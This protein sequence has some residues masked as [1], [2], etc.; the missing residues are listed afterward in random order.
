MRSFSAGTAARGRAFGDWEEWSVLGGDALAG[1][2]DGPAP[3]VRG[4]PLAPEEE[5]HHRDDVEHPDDGLDHGRL[6]CEVDG[7]AQQRPVPAVGRDAATAAAEVKKA[8]LRTSGDP[9]EAWSWTD[10]NGRNVHNTDR[11]HDR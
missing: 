2:L 4:A 8:G 6:R 3:R 9:V 10:G 1:R 11:I 7:A 5:E